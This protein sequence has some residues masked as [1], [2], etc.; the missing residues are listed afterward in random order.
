MLVDVDD[1]GDWWRRKV[2][3]DVDDGGECWRRKVLDEGDDIM[4]LDVDGVGEGRC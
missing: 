2:L 1:S 3:D 4:K